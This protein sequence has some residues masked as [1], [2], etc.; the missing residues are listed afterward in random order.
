MSDLEDFIEFV[1]YARR[2]REP[3]PRRYLRDYGDP[4]RKYSSIEFHARYRFTPEAVKDKILPL[5]E[6]DL[7]RPTRRGLPFG[8][9]IMLLVTLRFFATGS[10]Q[11]S[12]QEKRP[13][14][15]LFVLSSSLTS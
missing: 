8:P 5:V 14:G 1:D 4:F 2:H 7:R 9:E 13:T 10:F 11:V 6:T 15:F 3:G 12:F